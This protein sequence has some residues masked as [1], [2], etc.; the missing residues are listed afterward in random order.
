MLSM[1]GFGRG[2]A[3]TEIGTII[4]EMKTV[5]HRYLDIAVR[6]PKEFNALEEELRSLVRRQLTRGR[7][8][9][10]IRF[11]P[12]MQLEPVVSVN[13]ALAKAYL[14]Q[15][16]TLMQET[17]L[18]AAPTPIELLQ[19]PEVVRLDDPVV[20]P[21]LL[22]SPLVQ[23]SEQ[24]LRQ[25][26]EMRS[27]EGHCIA[28]DMEARLGALEV[29]LTA[30]AGRSP[31]V[32]K[33]YKQGLAKR[34]QELLQENMIDEVRL[35]QEVAIMADRA[36]ITEEI[37]RLRSHLAQLQGLLQS[38]KAVGRKLDFL[39]QEINREVNTIGSKANDT[40]ITQLVVDMKSELEK[41]RE[42]AQNVE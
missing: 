17:G 34:L 18:T 32:V 15:I 6:S 5:N 4:V 19:L 30:V 3:T 2:E 40:E 42:Q 28:G 36:C 38:E 10:Y 37:V 25:V 12:S 29:L 39:L 8:D 13:M 33:E 9:I 26:V 16:N 1:T 24:A 31:E 14:Q 21:A 23:A 20:D 7:V 27:Q 41:I 11:S 35:A 22:R